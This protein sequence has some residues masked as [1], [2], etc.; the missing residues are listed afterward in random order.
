MQNTKTEPTFRP[1]YFVATSELGTPNAITWEKT[2]A[3]TFDGAKRLAAKLPRRLTTTAQ[4]AF[5][6]EQ[7]EIKTIATLE[8]F[9]A[10]TRRRPTWRVHRLKMTDSA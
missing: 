5:Q 2:R 10:I 8:D 7:G 4:V 1:P 9:S 6:N 3:I